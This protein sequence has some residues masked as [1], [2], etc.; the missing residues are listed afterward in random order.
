MLCILIG[1][2]FIFFDINISYINL[3]PDFLG[4]LLTALGIAFMPHKRPA[5][6]RAQMIALVLMVLSFIKGIPIIKFIFLIFFY[7]T[8]LI[9]AGVREIETDTGHG[10]NSENLFFWFKFL[11]AAQSAMYAAVFATELF[12]PHLRVL[13]LFF[14]ALN[15]AM[16]IMFLLSLNRSRILYSDLTK[17]GDGQAHI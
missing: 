8:Y 1:Y 7:M 6:S 10:L 15:L 14:M 11:I 5:L 3:L 9:V 17:N 4:Y 13:L 16:C 2:I 12:F